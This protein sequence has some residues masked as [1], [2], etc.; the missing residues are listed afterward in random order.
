MQDYHEYLETYGTR[1]GAEKAWFY[2]EEKIT[3]LEKDL[4]ESKELCKILA[5]KITNNGKESEK[6]I[7][8]NQTCRKN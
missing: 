2:L 3:K 4:K 7:Q 8:N 1:K 6:I 5:N